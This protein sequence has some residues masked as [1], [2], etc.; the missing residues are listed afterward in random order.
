MRAII[1]SLTNYCSVCWTWVVVAVQ[2][3]SSPRLFPSSSAHASSEQLAECWPV[4]GTRN[5][6]PGALLRLPGAV[7]SAAAVAGWPA[8]FRGPVARS[9]RRD[10][11]RTDSCSRIPAVAAASLPAPLSSSSSC[12]RKW[13]FLL[14][15]PSRSRPR[16][17]AAAESDDGSGTAWSWANVGTAVA[18][19]AEQMASISVAQ[20]WT[21]STL[22]RAPCGW[23]C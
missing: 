8:D 4:P 14:R 13:A 18:R 10:F 11:L 19:P 21:N 12:C 6:R 1:P 3:C 5:H 20:G 7:P 2:P 22:A 23:D 9:S 15:C 17:A 16:T